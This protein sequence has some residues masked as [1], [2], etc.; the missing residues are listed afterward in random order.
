MDERRE[1]QIEK[2]K[3]MQMDVKIKQ[4]SKLKKLTVHLKEYVTSASAVS[5]LV[6][7]VE[8]TML[9]SLFR[10]RASFLMNYS[11]KILSIQI[12]ELLHTC[13]VSVCQNKYF[14]SRNSS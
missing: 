3:I 7:T 11:I 14:L 2:G 10:L 5:I 6:M 4:V 9:M 8:L 12:N 1:K 13:F